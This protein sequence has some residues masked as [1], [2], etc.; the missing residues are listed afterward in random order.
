LVAET[1]HRVAAPFWEFMNASGLVHQDDENVEAPL[2]ESPYFATGLPISEAY[3][4]SVTVN[5][6][7][8]DVLIQ[9]FERRVLTYTPDNEPAWQVE[10][11]NVGRHYYQWRYGTTP[12]DEPPA[13]PS[14]TQSIGPTPLPSFFD[15]A[16][17][18]RLTIANHAPQPLSITL[19][20][21][22][23]QTIDLPACDGCQSTDQP[24]S[25]CSPDAPATTLDIAPGSYLLTSSRPNGNVLPLSGPWTLAPNAGYGACFFVVTE[26]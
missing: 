26:G 2:F 23:S 11:G 10:A 12:P 5:G 25:S 18:S 3:W 17:R 20:G 14:G 9:V 19:A 1:N 4:A 6:Q 16:G 13:T 24:P 22:A 7:P 8:R 21:P 15:N